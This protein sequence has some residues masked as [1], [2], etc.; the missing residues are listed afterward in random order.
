[1]HDDQRQHRGHEHADD[2]PQDPAAFWEARYA[3]SERVWSGR[4]NATLVSVAAELAPGSALDLACGE[5]ADVLWLAE[6]GWHATGVDISTT[7]LERGRAA[8]AAAGLT[9]R[10]TFLAADLSDWQPTASYDLVTSS[11]LHSPVALAREEILARAAQAV[12]PGGHLLVVAHAAAPPWARHHLHDR[13][14]TPQEDVAALVGDSPEWTVV[15]A[16]VRVRQ[17]QTPDGEPAELEDGVVLLRR[18]PV[19]SGD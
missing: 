8:A 12:A 6:H 7:A 5:G 9:E 13:F 19:S 1:M 14:P 17:G 10:A 18:A 15:I 2:S 11:F 3:G 16:E 4:A